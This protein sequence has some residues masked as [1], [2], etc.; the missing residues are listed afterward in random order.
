MNWYNIELSLTRAEKLQ[1]LLYN[2]GI[3]FEISAAGSWYHF[4]ILLDPEGPEKKTVEKFLYSG[5]VEEVRTC[6]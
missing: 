5:A 2:T 6:I 4:E 3:N 1:Q